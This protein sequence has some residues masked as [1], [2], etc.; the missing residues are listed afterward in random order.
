M[1]LAP[2][3]PGASQADAPPAKLQVAPVHTLEPRECRAQDLQRPVEGAGGFSSPGLLDEGG[4][5]GGEPCYDLSMRTFRP[6]A[7][8]LARDAGLLQPLGLLSEPHGPL[9]IRGV[10]VEVLA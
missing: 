3:D 9:Q 6:V 1:S 4:P 10:D 5:Q 2:S 7:G 8:A